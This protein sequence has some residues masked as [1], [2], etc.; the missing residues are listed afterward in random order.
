MSEKWLKALRAAVG[1]VVVVIL[2]FVVNGYWRQY[3]TASGVR[4]T[5][6][7]ATAD[8]TSSVAAAVGAT[9]GQVVVVMIDGLNLRERPSATA[10]S[11][12]GLKKGDSLALITKQDSWLQV[13]DASGQ[14]GWVVNNPQ[15]VVIRKK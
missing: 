2:V 9:D 13:K 10:K 14:A 15:Y 7:T 3:K 5:E 8:A 11:Y 6:T 4:K 1:L 12:R